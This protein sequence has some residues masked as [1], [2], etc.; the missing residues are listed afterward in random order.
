MPVA[1]RLRREGNRNRAFYRIVVAD[2]RARRDGRFIEMIGTYD[3]NEKGTNF[4]VDIERADDWITK[5]AQPSETVRS[6]LRKARRGI[7]V[8]DTAKLAEEGEG[9]EEEA[10]PLSSQPQAAPAAEKPMQGIFVHMPPLWAPSLRRPAAEKP[11][12][13]VKPEADS[14]TEKKTELEAQK[15][16]EPEAQKDAEPEASEGASE[17]T[18]DSGG[19]PAQADASKA[20]VEGASAKVEGDGEPEGEQ[21]AE[22]KEKEKEES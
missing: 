14:N 20:P 15:D 1:I 11:A 9:G 4:Q 3:P 10:A 5:G 16:A 17:A 2:S 6:L 19:E 12:A 21:K 7:G 8:A 22:P 18:S 13:E